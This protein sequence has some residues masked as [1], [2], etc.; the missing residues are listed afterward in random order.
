MNS[1]ERLKEEYND[2]LANPLSNI[3]YTVGL[4]NYDNIY[5]WKLAFICPKDSI[6][7]DGLFYVKL[8]FPKNYPFKAPQMIFLTP[9]YHFNVN[10]KKSDDLPLG[11]ASMNVTNFWRP[12][13]TVRELITQFYCFFYCHDPDSPFDLNRA[14]EYKENRPLFEKKAK[15]FTQKYANPSNKLEQ[16][17]EK[18]WE[19]SCSEKDLEPIKL[20]EKEEEKGKENGEDKSKEDINLTFTY[21]GKITTTVQCGTDELMKNVIEKCMSK[22]GISENLEKLLVIFL[23]KK[24]DLNSSVKDNR[25]KNNSNPDIILNCVC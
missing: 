20:K 23:G 5:E 21:N 15:Y 2:I 3:A 22:L 25:L 9:I 19:F 14:K 8:L 24:L 13:T 1:L 11:Y 6:Y 10:P 7:G 18:D 4:L 12:E 17:D 16:F